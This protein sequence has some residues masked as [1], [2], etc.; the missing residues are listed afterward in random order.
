V[1]KKC[2]KCGAEMY[3][4]EK[5][6]WFCPDCVLEDLDP[7]FLDQSQA[8]AGE[9]KKPFVLQPPTKPVSIRIAIQ[10]LE[11]AK[12]LA[13]KKGIPKYQ[14]YLKTLLHEAL[15][16]EESRPY[17]PTRTGISKKRRYSKS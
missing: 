17:A 2:G 3:R 10:D 6:R 8:D 7:A 1:K 15:I 14:T 12:N 4:D 9:L 11:R 16:K 5:G 13:R